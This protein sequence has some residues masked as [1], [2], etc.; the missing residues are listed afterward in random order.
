MEL[1]LRGGILHDP[2]AGWSGPA[3]ILIRGRRIEAISRS[4]GN[5]DVPALDLDGKIILPGLIDMH[6]HLREPGGESQETIASGCA[7]AVAGGFTS[8]ACM[9]NTLPPAD[10]KTVISYIKERARRADL[11]RVYPIGTISQ[12]SRGE[13]LA[14]MWELAEEGA[15][16]F[17]DD[18]WPVMDG[19]L[20]RGAMQVAMSLGLPIISHCEDLTIADQGVVHAGPVGYRLGL[21]VIRPAAE[22]AMVA[23]D[24]LLQEEVGGKLHLA[25]ISSRKSVAL[26]K[27]AAERGI[28]FTAEVT[29]HHL[30]LTEEAV[31]GFS[32]DAKMNPPLR[33]AADRTALQQA[34]SD[35]LI[36]VVA[37]D[38]APHRQLDKEKDFLGAPFGVVGLETAL[39]LILSQLLSKGRISWEQ[40]VGFLSIA[41]SRILNIPGGTLVPGAE[42]DLVVID[43]QQE[44]RVERN[45]FYSQGKN[46]P[47]QGWTLKGYPVLTMVSGDIKM[48]AGKVKGFSRDFKETV[49]AATHRESI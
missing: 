14:N 48:L 49:D 43:L 7:A 31:E 9:P 11:A 46:T 34:L 29:P 27:W 44:R 35:G 4:I 16:G 18:G 12:G 21:P 47:F 17:S 22:A 24:L 42:A 39:P 38:H 32:T 26:L 30:F 6:V 45:D 15:R 37:T 23:R 2:L 13:E 40:L 36:G 10:N 8:L 3:E 19:G 1:L 20:M 33:G 41:P 25:H 5:V 28:M